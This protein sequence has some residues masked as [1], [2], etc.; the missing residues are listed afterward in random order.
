MSKPQKGK[1]FRY[2]L[3]T[4]L[5]VRNIRETQQNEVFQAAE[6]KVIEEK[7]PNE[8]LKGY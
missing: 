4:L 6:K 8:L 3:E 7:A 2:K 5:K 1:R